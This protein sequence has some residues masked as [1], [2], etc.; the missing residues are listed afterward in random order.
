MS[1][2]VSFIGTG[3][4]G[5][6]LLRG[7]HR[8]E[9]IRLT[10]FDVDT[11]K[12]TDLCAECSAEAMPSAAEATAQGDFVLLCVKPQHLHDVLKTLRPALTEAKCLVSIAAGITQAQISALIG[13]ICPVVRV[14]PNTPALV[15]A[16][17]LAVCLDDPKLTAAQK[18]FVQQA[19]NAVGEVHVLAEKLFDAFTA[20]AGSGPA[21]VFYFMEALV[22]AALACGLPRPQATRIVEGLFAGSVKLAG[23]SGTHLS[24]LRE[25][26]TSPAGTTVA[27]L[28]HLDRQ[29]VRAAIMDAVAQAMRRS[30]ELS[31]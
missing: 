22:E 20:V 4:M 11:R 16:G 31:E 10:A 27:A 28:T 6:A 15:G 2:T 13:T 17:V 24:L 18:E 1:P 7:M 14:M 5:G 23:Q 29:A 8:L 30:R 9:G 19:M 12:L 3:N 21:Y 26:V 25:M